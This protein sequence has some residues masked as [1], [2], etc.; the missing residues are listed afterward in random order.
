MSIKEAQTG[1]LL[2][3][4]LTTGGTGNT[5][6]ITKT[7][8]A[9]DGPISDESMAKFTATIDINESQLIEVTAYGPMAN[10]QATSKVSA[11]QWVVPGNPQ[12]QSYRR[13]YPATSK[14][15]SRFGL[16][17]CQPLFSGKH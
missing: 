15:A 2:A 13:G 8:I 16:V 1:E 7:P 6:R 5:M 10:L 17:V 14:E 4:R 9:R 11:T 3:K 12:S